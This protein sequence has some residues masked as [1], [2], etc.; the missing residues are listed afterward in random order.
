[1]PQGVAGIM[2][3]VIVGYSVR[4]G[5]HRWAWIVACC[6]MG[7]LGGGLISFLPASDHAGL[8]A[9]IYLVS[10]ITPTLS[11]LYQWTATNVAGSTKR[12]VSLAL[13]AG[14][15]SAGSVIAP[16]TFQAKDAPQ[17]LPAKI[18][19]LASQV[20]GALL[21]FLLFCYYVWA[22]KHRSRKGASLESRNV[23][24]DEQHLWEDLTDRKNPTFRYV[25]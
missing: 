5:S 7:I 9:G 15:F 23:Q 13:I 25:Y 19:A 2:A 12:A 10:A 18:T 4:Q 21:A 1:M 3:T 22:N 11:L 24:G 17:Y 14:S 16:Q 8:L 20:A 6:M